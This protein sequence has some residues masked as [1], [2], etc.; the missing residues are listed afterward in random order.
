MAWV[1]CREKGKLERLRF[2]DLV[3]GRKGRGR[4]RYVVRR[5]SGDAILRALRDT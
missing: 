1:E 2:V 3:F 4:T 5:Y